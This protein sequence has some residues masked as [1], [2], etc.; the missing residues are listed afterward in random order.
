MAERKPTPADFPILMSA[1]AWQ[2]VHGR[3]WPP[4]SAGICPVCR[5]AMDPRLVTRHAKA[6]NRRKRLDPRM[7]AEWRYDML[8]PDRDNNPHRKEQ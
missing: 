5:L 4:R 2:R 6:C 7:W 8:H 3:S 1:S